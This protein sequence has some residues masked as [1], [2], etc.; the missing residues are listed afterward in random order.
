[1]SETTVKRIHISGIT[2]NIS[3]DDLK[4]RLSTFAK[5][6]ALDGLGAKDSLGA[7]RRFAYATLEGPPAQITRCVAALSGATWKGARLRVGDAKPDFRERIKRENEAADSE[8]E[9]PKK[10]RRRTAATHAPDMDPVTPDRAEGKAGWTVTPLGRTYFSARMRPERPL[11]PPPGEATQEGKKKKRARAPPTRARRRKIDMGKWGS[12]QLK[13]VFVDTSALPSPDVILGRGKAATQASREVYPDDTGSESDEQEEEE[14]LDDREAP[15]DKD[16]EHEDAADRMSVDATPSTPLPPPP[17][18]VESN[19]PPSDIAREQAKNVDFLRFLFG[20]TDDWGGREEVD[21]VALREAEARERLRP[22]KRAT[23]DD[24]FEIAPVSPAKKTQNTPAAQKTVVEARSSSPTISEA[25]SASSAASL[26][27]S[28]SPSP[29]T[30]AAPKATGPAKLKD[31][32][33][34]R[35]EEPGFSLLG[36]LDIDLELDEDAPFPIEPTDP[37]SAQNDASRIP[38]HQTYT[39]PVVT[40]TATAAGP[41]VLDTSKPFFF[42]RSGRGQ[43]VRDVARA[44]KWDWKGAAFHRPIEGNVE[45]LARARWEASKLELTR[46]WKR[47][48]REAARLRRRRGGGAEE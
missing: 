19:L 17:P 36:A 15:D 11:P 38:F 37:T 2:P 21:D 5:V 18:P 3:H 1:M 9:R 43:D 10:R 29:E 46:D 31:L 7:P 24:D 23:E 34:P 30:A 26:E 47:R 12:T 33:A 48:W 4:Q 25:E 28:S 39:A 22:A 13:G 41:L 20:D 32:F 16:D 45:E 6:S 27:E 8:G 40:T 35:D 44:N 42:P 14:H